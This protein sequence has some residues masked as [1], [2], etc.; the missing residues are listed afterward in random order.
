MWFASARSIQMS[1]DLDIAPP[2]I[3]AVNR[4]VVEKDKQPFDRAGN[5][6][7]WTEDPDK[8]KIFQ[9]MSFNEAV[10]LWKNNPEKY[11]LKL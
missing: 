10:E 11:D 4:W 8:D 1:I 5:G 9:F 6:N 2:E 3:Q 7:N